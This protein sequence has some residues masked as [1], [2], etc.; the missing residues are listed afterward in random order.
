MSG[1]WGIFLQGLP[2]LLAAILAAW[3]LRHTTVIRQQVITLEKNTNS[4]KDALIQATAAS[5]FAQGV[6][7]EQDKATLSLQ[8]AAAADVA[9]A[10]LKVA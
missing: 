10:K 5:A 6:K 7:Q 2:A 3:N 4:I 9:A 8:Q 1:L